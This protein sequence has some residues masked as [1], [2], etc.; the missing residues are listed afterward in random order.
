MQFEGLSNERDLAMSGFSNQ[1]L[2][3]HKPQVSAKLRTEN[4]E[5]HPPHNLIE[6]PRPPVRFP[7]MLLGPH[8]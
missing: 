2:G 8:Y 5:P 7:E 3:A 6:G 1:F 4:I